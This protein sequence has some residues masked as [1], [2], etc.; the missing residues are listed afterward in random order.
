M[1]RHAVKI[2]TYSISRCLSCIFGA[3]R[4]VEIA[5][6]FFFLVPFFGDLDEKLA[7]MIW[8]MKYFVMSRSLIMLNILVILLEELCSTIYRQKMVL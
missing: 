5:V 8:K 1:L 7:I 2:F 6:T 4:I 3:E